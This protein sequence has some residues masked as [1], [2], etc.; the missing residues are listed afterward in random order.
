[1][2][3]FVKIC[4]F[5]TVDSLEAAVES[6]VD[7]VG[8]VTGVPSSPRNLRLDE[9]KELISLVP[10]DV[11]SV[12]VMA[13]NS[14][15]QVRQAVDYIRPDMV[16]VHGL[17]AV[18]VGIPLILG[19]NN[20]ADIRAAKSLSKHCDL[21]LLDSYKEGVHGGTGIQQDLSFSKNFIEQLVPQPVILAGGLTHTNV[22]HAIKTTQPYG[23]DVSSGVERS[24][25]EK[26]PELIR[27]FI[28]AA[29]EQT[30]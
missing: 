22:A 5:K 7:A 18:G 29:K 2:T 23:V 27:A 13:P 19:V 10:S 4:G 9:V 20:G 16:Q 24:P 12:L 1:M 6:G 26:D 28:E 30:Q 3:I 15:E 25:G 8:F 21:L 17:D 14:V 11:K